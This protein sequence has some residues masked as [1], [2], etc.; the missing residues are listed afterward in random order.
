MKKPIFRIRKVKKNT[1]LPEED[2]MLIKLVLSTSKPKW[3][4]ISF[5]L[6][7]KIYDCVLRYNKITPV[8]KKGEWTIEEDNQ[9]IEGVNLYGK[10]FRK[11]AKTFKD[12][13][14]KQ[15]RERYINYLDPLVCRQKFTLDEDLLILK[16]QSIYGN[17][18]SIIR[19]HLPHRSA[20][21]IKNRYKSSIC[22][23]VRIL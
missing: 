13:T 18:W 16:L 23:N 21:M 4:K 19:N 2:E 8:I 17:K 9:I 6:K 5:I 3:K 14:S 20:D 1:W 11:I 22:R 10:N 15:V 12:R 7:K